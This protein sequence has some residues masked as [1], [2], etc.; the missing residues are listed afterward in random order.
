MMVGAAG[1][2]A[3]YNVLS[4]PYPALSFTGFAMLAGSLAML[5]LAL[6]GV[7]GAALALYLG[8]F[9]LERITPTGVA[10]TVT[11]NPVMAL[12]LGV[13]LMG[14]PWSAKFL[15]GLVGVAVGVALVKLAP[16][17]LGPAAQA[18]PSGMPTTLNSGSSL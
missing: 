6:L 9:A 1:C 16:M 8:G 11:L 15:L 2:G 13:G 10:V 5:L 12:S 7:A 3:L 4:Q 17:R 18:K 14:E